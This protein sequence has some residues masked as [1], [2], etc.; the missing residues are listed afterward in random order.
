MKVLLDTSVLIAGVHPSH[1]SHSVALPWLDAAKQKK[2]DCV[3]SAHSIAECYAVLTRLPVR[4]R[5]TGPTA[6]QLIRDLLTDVVAVSLSSDDY[7]DLLDDLSK[8]RFVGGVVYDGIMAK[9][10][11]MEN[12]DYLLTLN[13]S[14]FQRLWPAGSSRIVSPYSLLPP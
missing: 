5:I 14:D 7:L 4:P 6:I 11:Q 10:A 12:V 3:I 9:A 13:E 2:F 8:R 1:A